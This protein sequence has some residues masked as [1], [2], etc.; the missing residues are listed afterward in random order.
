MTPAPDSAVGVKI[1]ANHRRQPLSMSLTMTIRTSLFVPL[2]AVALLLTGLPAPAAAST[3]STTL[4]EQRLRRLVEAE[5]AAFAQLEIAATEAD[6]ES[7]EHRL[8]SIIRQYDGLLREAPEFAPVYVA[9]GLLLE[10]VEER[11][12]AVRMFLAANQFDPN[13]PL[14]KNQIGNYLAEEGKYKEALPYYLAAIELEPDESLYHYQ[15]GS[16][17]HGYRRFFIRDGLYSAD[18]LGRESQQAFRRAAELQPDKI[19]FAYRYAESYYDLAESDWPAALKVWRELLGRVEDN[20]ERQTVRLH[21][22]NVLMK[23]GRNEEAADILRDIGHPALAGNRRVL[24]QRLE[25]AQRI[26]DG[27]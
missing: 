4:I 20:L 10:R 5:R 1:A 25:A 17:L 13:I 26:T 24:L 15:L 21:E 3:E 2:L 7:V 6:R 12:K 14:V 23:L 16:L 9:F 22:A 8:Q 18:T 27:R 19:P 11:E